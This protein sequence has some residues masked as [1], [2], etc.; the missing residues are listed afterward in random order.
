[1]LFAATQLMATAA[2]TLLLAKRA[3]RPGRVRMTRLGLAVSGV[4]F[5][6]AAAVTDPVTLVLANLVLGAGLGAV[7]CIVQVMGGSRRPPDQSRP[8]PGGV[9]NWRPVPH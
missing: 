1:M 9:V 7:R 2:V 5:L 8:R 4:G 6:G 3:A